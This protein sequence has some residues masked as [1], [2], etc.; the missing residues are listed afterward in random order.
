[1]KKPDHWLLDSLKSPIFWIIV[2]VS[3]VANILARIL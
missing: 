3:L 2:T 1:M